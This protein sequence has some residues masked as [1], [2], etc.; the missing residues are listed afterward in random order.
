M[1]FV[2]DAGSEVNVELN[3]KLKSQRTEIIIPPNRRTRATTT[4]Q[5]RKPMNSTQTNFSRRCHKCETTKTP[6][7]R[8]GPD[9]IFVYFNYSHTNLTLLLWCDVVTGPK[10]LCNACGVR[11]SRERQDKTKP[12]KSKKSK[13]K[14]GVRNSGSFCV[15]KKR[16]RSL[17]RDIRRYDIAVL[18]PNNKQLSMRSY[19]EDEFTRKEYTAAL[20][21]VSLAILGSSTS[22]ETG[23]TAKMEEIETCCASKMDPIRAPNANRR[24]SQRIME[25]NKSCTHYYGGFNFDE[26]VPNFMD[27]DEASGCEGPSPSSTHDESVA[28]GFPCIWAAMS[29]YK[30][31][32]HVPLKKSS[33][34]ESFQ[35]HVC[36]SSA[37]NSAKSDA[38]TLIKSNDQT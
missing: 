35:A 19:Q 22:L 1:G 30:D 21:L 25:A 37:S 24:R 15:A 27:M 23:R 2:S 14:S 7:W 10:T 32:C 6:Q 18:F 33:Q 3:S 9:G 16:P 4:R 5:K 11:Y 29:P 12:R 34:D 20:S 13:S 28:M 36:P 31:L 17:N 26:W 38:V 8:E